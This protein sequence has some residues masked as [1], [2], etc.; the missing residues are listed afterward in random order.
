MKVLKYCKTLGRTQYE[1]VPALARELAA[2]APPPGVTLSPSALSLRLHFADAAAVAAR[3]NPGFVEFGHGSVEA[4]TD[5]VV[6]S[7]P[8]RPA[9]LRAVLVPVDPSC[10]HLDPTDEWFFL[11]GLCL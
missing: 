3:L 6:E 2:T 8:Q 10:A 5:I 11:L 7:D 4:A 1:Q 9:T